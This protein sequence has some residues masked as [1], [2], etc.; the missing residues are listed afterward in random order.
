MLDA[1]V[2]RQGSRWRAGVLMSWYFAAMIALLWGGCYARAAPPL[3]A[4]STIQERTFAAFDAMWGRRVEFTL[5][6]GRVIVGWAAGTDG[7]RRWAGEGLSV[8]D[9]PSW[10]FEAR[11]GTHAVLW[12][13]L[14]AIERYPGNAV[15]VERARLI[16][17]SIAWVGEQC[18]GGWPQD[19]AVIGGVWCNTSIW[20]GRRNVVDPGQPRFHTWDDSV[21]ASGV[22]VMAKAHRVLG[23]ERYL[24]AARKPY[25][26]LRQWWATDP[27]L[28]GAVPQVLPIERATALRLNQNG[29]PR[30]ADTP[31]YMAKFNV[32]DRAAATA[33][34]GAIDADERDVSNAIFRRLL[35]LPV[36]RDE[37][38]RLVYGG[39][40]PQCV[41]AYT[42]LGV[43][44]R[45]KERGSVVVNGRTCYVV[46]VCESGVPEALARLAMESRWERHPNGQ[47][48]P[49]DQISAAAALTTDMYYTRLLRVPLA[50]ASAGQAWRN[51]AVVGDDPA[52][53]LPVFADNE[54]R[55]WVGAEHESKAG[56][57]QLW[58][59]GFDP[60]TARNWARAKTQ[61]WTLKR[62]LDQRKM[63]AENVL[64]L[65]TVNLADNLARQKPHGLWTRDD[66]MDWTGETCNRINTLLEAR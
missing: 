62:L 42:S 22:V 12:L 30:N 9:A 38:G 10:C 57:G 25:A 58:R 4:T 11:D 55:H 35:A 64:S 59:A 46:T 52:T 37:Q 44:A 66:G 5:P 27:R 21:T 39:A 8:G 15:L 60:S 20:G 19:G 6:D 50:D 1:Q 2:E 43:T 40:W 23:D 18:G 45:G 14:K 3:T 16:A 54:F 28:I 24:L 51:Y 48:I 7:V 61:G 65:V 53:W 31:A 36:M 34:V 29:D 26:A 13:H 32:N 63:T 33:A 56:S 41:N 17:D 49:V 47:E